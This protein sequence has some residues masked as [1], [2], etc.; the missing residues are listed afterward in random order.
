MVGRYTRLR[1]THA[2]LLILFR[3]FATFTFVCTDWFAYVLPRAVVLP[4]FSPR[5]LRLPFYRLVTRCVVYCCCLVLRSLV[6]WFTFSAHTFALPRCVLQITPVLLPCS[7]CRLP[8]TRCVHVQLH[9]PVTHY[10]YVWLYGWFV[11]ARLLDFAFAFTVL[12]LRVI[13]FWLP[14][15]VCYVLFTVRLLYVLITRFADSALYVDYVR[16]RLLFS[17]LRY[18][19]SYVYPGYAFVTLRLRLFTF[20]FVRYRLRLPVARFT[21]VRYVYVYGL[22]CTRY[23]LLDSV[24]FAFTVCHTLTRCFRVPFRVTVVGYVA[25]THVDWLRYVTRTR[26]HTFTLHVCGCVLPHVS[27]FLLRCCDR[28]AAFTVLPYTIPLLPHPVCARVPL[29]VPFLRLF[30]HTTVCLIAFDFSSFI[31][32]GYAFT[33][34]CL[35]AVTRFRLRLR[36]PR[37]AT[38][39][40]LPFTGCCYPGL[41]HPVDCQFADFTLRWLR[42]AVYVIT[43][44]AV[45]YYGLRGLITFLH[46]CTFVYCFTFHAVVARYVILRLFTARVTV[47]LITPT[48]FAFYALPDYYAFT[49]DLRWLPFTFTFTL[50]FWFLRHT[51]A[52]LPVWLRCWT[53][54]PRVDYVTFPFVRLHC[55][56]VLLRLRLP[57]FVTRLLL[58]FC[59]ST[60]RCWIA[61]RYVY[62]LISRCTFYYVTVY[63]FAVGLL[64]AFCR[65]VTHVLRFDSVFVYLRTFTVCSGLVAIT[66]TVPGFVVTFAFALRLRS[67]LRSHH[68]YFTVY[69]GY[70][71]RSFAFHLLLRLRW[72]VI[73]WFAHTTRLRLRLRPRCVYRTRLRTLLRFR[74]GYALLVAGFTFTFVPVPFARTVPDS[75]C[76]V[77]GFR[78]FFYTLPFRATGYLVAFGWLLIHTRFTLVA[79]TRC[80]VR[81]V[82]FR[83][84]LRSAL[85]A[86]AVHLR[87]LITFTVVCVWLHGL[88]DYLYR[89]VDFTFTTFALRC[90]VDFVCNWFCCACVRSFAVYRIT[91]VTHTFTPLHGYYVHAL[92][93][94]RTFYVA[95]ADC[96]L[97]YTFAFAFTLVTVYSLVRLRCLRYLHVYALRL[98]FPFLRLFTFTRLVTLRL[99][100]TRTFTFHVGCTHLRL[101]LPQFPLLFCYTRCVYVCFDYTFAVFVCCD[102]CPLHFTT[103]AIVCCYIWLLFYRWFCYYVVVTGGVCDTLFCGIRILF[104]VPVDCSFRCWLI[105]V[106]RL[107]TLRCFATALIDSTFCWL[108]TFCC[109]FA[110]T[111]TFYARWLHSCDFFLFVLRVLL[112]TRVTLRF[113]Y[114][115]CVYGSVTV[116]VPLPFY[117]TNVTAV[118]SFTWFYVGC[119][120]L[121]VSP[122][123]LRLPRFT[124]R[125]VIHRS[126]RFAVAVGLPHTRYAHRLVA[127]TLVRFRLVTRSA[128]SPSRFVYTRTVLLRFQ[129]RVCVCLRSLRFTTRLLRVWLRCLVGSQLP[130]CSGFVPFA[131]LVCLQHLRCV[132]LR[133]GAFD[134]L[135]LFRLR[136]TLL[137]LIGLLP[138]PTLARLRFAAFVTRCVVPHP[139]PVYLPH[140]RSHVVCTRLPARLLFTLVG[141]PDYAYCPDARLIGYDFALRTDT[142]A[143]LRTRWFPTLIRSYVDYRLPWFVT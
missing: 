103:V 137:R 5:S 84:G 139:V 129:F 73:D 34:R 26:S 4:A 19:C 69:V 99:D 15:H 65:T 8:F 67:W 31:T 40:R 134:L 35:R 51:H 101:R 142:V 62:V 43:R 135:R 61:I 125:F 27:R 44:T 122:L 14:L 83:S 57:L 143:R 112:V 118:G 6:C 95:P 130:S 132:D 45:G 126:S 29:P 108:R 7:Y 140:V 117:R 28:F 138:L 30:L 75:I 71:L 22:V 109:A 46:D 18:V 89:L 74:S 88:R 55:D 72:F 110:V 120:T 54:F 91:P 33:L 85:P 32:R 100:F 86:F 111:R 39:T 133:F 128:F 64:H 90:S 98:Q 37:V 68:V 10:V 36:L 82:V 56:C 16:L 42:V 11:C 9:V 53:L 97:P 24:D 96:W 104:P 49:F 94:F 66:V 81:L 48:R 141:L 78:L 21:F 124:A 136:F 38:F 77:F 131:Q 60:L 102:C 1:I 76:Y 70:G 52:R 113:A 80:Y 50:R 2:T 127:L 116:F 93:H 47:I 114:V 17:W 63:T 12:P 121:P 41:L 87:S 106:L 58:P 25:F 123:R 13:T 79:F 20:T 119:T 3:A 107:C 115:C 59:N 105:Y 23:V 92:P